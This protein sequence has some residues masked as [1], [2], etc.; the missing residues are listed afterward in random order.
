MKVYCI[1]NQD[2]YCKLTL[3]GSYNTE[4]NKSE[5]YQMY[6]NEGEMKKYLKNKFV[7]SK[8][9]AELIID[10]K[11]N[12]TNYY[13]PISIALHISHNIEQ[14]QS[15]LGLILLNIDDSMN[16]VGNIYEFLNIKPNYD[17]IISSSSRNA[18]YNKTSSYVQL[19]KLKNFM[20]TIKNGTNSNIIDLA[21][22]IQK[23]IDEINKVLIYKKKEKKLAY[24]IEHEPNGKRYYFKSDDLCYTRESQYKEGTLVI[25]NTVRGEQ[26]GIIRGTGFIPEAKY[27][28]LK[29][30][31]PKTI[32]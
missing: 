4:D 23:S 3:G 16:G 13:Q 24:S 18:D 20:T 14:N 31:R 7:L 22:K 19:G 10:S 29:E 17:I 26:Y 1:N 8:E 15:T 21:Y 9:K 12:P 28:Q 2:G 25:C 27:N 30:F 6:D 5:F 32:I 11:N